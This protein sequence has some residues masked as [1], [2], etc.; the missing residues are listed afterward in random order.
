MHTVQLIDGALFLCE[1]EPLH[2]I[3]HPIKNGAN[4]MR[5]RWA[6]EFKTCHKIPCD[7]NPKWKEL[8]NQDVPNV[9]FVI[10]KEGY[11]CYYIWPDEPE[12]PAAIYVEWGVA[13]QG[14][15]DSKM[16]RPT[17][18]AIRGIKALEQH[19]YKLVLPEATNY[20]KK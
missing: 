16:I 7:S 15:L 10:T 19:G 12:P 6:D 1:I 13:V 18:D 2:P 11:A 4:P 9:N 17:V 5:E 8:V 3:G 20:K 14:L